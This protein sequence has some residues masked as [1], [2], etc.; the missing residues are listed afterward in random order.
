[1]ALLVKMVADLELP[2]SFDESVGKLSSRR[3]RKLGVIVTLSFRF[4]GEETRNIARAYLRVLDLDAYT[5]G[6]EMISS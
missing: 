1:L 4:F 6:K 5:E 3:R 2:F